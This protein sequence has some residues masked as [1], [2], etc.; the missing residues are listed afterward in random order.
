M[1]GYIAL[2]RKIIENEFYFSEKFTKSQ[3]WIDLL[4]LATHKENTVY[5]RGIGIK[6][7][8]GELCYSQL[9]L[10]RRW[11]WNFKTVKK[12]LNLL[13]KRE[14]VEIKSDNVTTVIFIKNWEH[15]QASRNELVKNTKIKG[16]QNGDQRETKM[17]TNN[18][19]NNVKN[20]IPAK[21]KRR[22]RSLETYKTESTLYSVVYLYTSINNRSIDSSDYGFVKH[23]LQ[24]KQNDNITYRIK[25][26]ML[27]YVIKYLQS[28]TTLPKY[29]GIL[30][31]TYRDLNYDDF[32]N[33]TNKKIDLNNEFSEYEVLN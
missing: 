27:C 11:K 24:L 31:N 9:S 12:F 7:N 14:M 3:A 22:S 33:S 18:N 20:R 17:E 15:Y 29:K 19:V 2:H 10:A 5:I 26:L 1:E 21:I 4:I 16:E 8:S 28:K 6:L 13:K 25:C 30:Y 23:L 32:K